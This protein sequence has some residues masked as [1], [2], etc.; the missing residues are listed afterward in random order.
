M[1]TGQRI[2]V[3][4]DE[5]LLRDLLSRALGQHGFVVDTAADGHAALER[6]AA[7]PPDVVLLDLMMPRMDG[8]EVLEHVRADPAT[9]GLQVIVLTARGGQE[10][11]QEA[12]EAGADDYISKPFHLGEVTARVKAHARIARYA[13]QMA[14][15]R[16]DDQTLLTISHRLTSHL[17]IRAILQDVA[18]MV[19]GVL[20]SER[21][22]VVLVEPNQQWGRVVAASDDAGITD[23]EIA[24]DGYPEIR[25]VL[26]TRKPLIVG[27][28]GAD[29]L[30]DPIKDQ[31]ARLAVRSCALF[32]M[33]EADRCIGVL[34]LRSTRPFDRLGQRETSFGQIVANAAAVAVSNARLFAGLRR[35]VT[36]ERAVGRQLAETRDFLQALIDATPDAVVATDLNGRVKVFN[37]AAE[38]LFGRPAELVTDRVHISALYPEGAADEIA[39]ALRGDEHGPP[40]RIT[41]PLRRDALDASGNAVPVLLTASVVQVDERDVATVYIVRDLRDRIAMETELNETQERLKESEKM[42]LLAELAG[43]MAH[44]LNQPLTS[45]MGYAELLQRRLPADDPNL[46]AV[47]TIHTEA[48]RMAA[49]VRRIGR[50]TRYETKAYV[51]QARILDLE[52]SSDDSESS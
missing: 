24:L 34:F 22:S 12:L 44:E 3:V 25:R 14:Q 48:E 27:D 38:A 50:L 51:G 42:A 15:Q 31:V 52:A 11:L 16:R 30:F 4:D 49:L 37:K 9:R 2:L 29:P 17:D 23:R 47:R 8:F 7:E 21:C 19:A 46:K 40:N 5:R 36:E 45:V 39:A 18:G 6:I 26:E 28:I 32:P 33:L 13:E 20:H 35:D 1:S 10:V 41:V 43:A